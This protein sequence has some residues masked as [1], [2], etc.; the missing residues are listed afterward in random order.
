METSIIIWIA[1]S[2]SFV[3]F[4]MGGIIGWIYRGTVDENTYKRQMDNLHPEFLNGNG[5]Y[6]NEE[7]LA[8]R[9]MDHEDLDEDDE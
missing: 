1:S 2:I 5:A 7:L 8:V 9:F 3:A 4:V 6:V